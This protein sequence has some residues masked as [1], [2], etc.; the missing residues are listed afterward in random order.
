MRTRRAPR[1]GRIQD[2]GG[3]AIS[4]PI[5]TARTAVSGA[6]RASKGASTLRFSLGDTATSHDPCVSAR[7]PVQTLP[8][9]HVGY[10]A[11][12]SRRRASEFRQPEGAINVDPHSCARFRIPG[13]RSFVSLNLSTDP[14]DHICRTPSRLWHHGPCVFLRHSTANDALT[15]VR[16]LQS[17]GASLVLFSSWD[18]GSEALYAAAGRPGWLG[19]HD[20]AS[21]EAILAAWSGAEHY[22]HSRATEAT[23]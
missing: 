8:R 18:A 10:C 12:N 2:M 19:Q 16:A 17:F 11:T 23:Q 7:G 14:I 9:P 5:S 20:P 21:A 4:Q 3:S 22:S 6:N 13:G 1:R 15:G